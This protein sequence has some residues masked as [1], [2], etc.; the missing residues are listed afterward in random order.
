[1]RSASLAL[2]RYLKLEDGS[3]IIIGPDACGKLMSTSDGFTP[4]IYMTGS[5]SPNTTDVHMLTDCIGCEAGY[6]WSLS[7]GVGCCQKGSVTQPTELESCKQ[8]WANTNC[9]H[10]PDGHVYGNNGQAAIQLDA[11]TNLPLG[12]Y[13]HSCHGCV[14]DAPILS[15]EACQDGKKGCRGDDYSSCV[16]DTKAMADLTGCDAGK[17]ENEH[18]QLSP[19]CP[20]GGGHRGMPGG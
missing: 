2:R 3:D 19:Y 11:D 16:T 12:S 18:G 15:C 4:A 8:N 5:A 14:Y 1:M 13:V 7:S 9:L 17:I 6:G 20:G 10:G